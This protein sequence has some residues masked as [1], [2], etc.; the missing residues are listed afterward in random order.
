M[1][2]ILMSTL[3]YWYTLWSFTVWSWVDLPL[4]RPKLGN[5]PLLWALWAEGS[6]ESS[7]G[8]RNGISSVAT[9]TWAAC[10]GVLQ[11]FRAAI[12]YPVSIGINMCIHH[13]SSLMHRLHRSW[14]FRNCRY[15]PIIIPLWT[16]T[17]HYKPLQ[18]TSG[19]DVSI[20]RLQPKVLGSPG[21]NP[22]IIEGSG[23]FPFES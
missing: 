15:H 19:L 18:T 1:E 2:A 23:V 5:Q 21:D 10:H 7:L 12:L 22:P 8:K 11:C 4:K 6:N 16:T 17:N 9:R 14:Y 20:W 13:H 3:V